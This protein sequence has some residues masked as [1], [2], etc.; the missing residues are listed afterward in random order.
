[1]INSGCSLEKEFS[2]LICM[3]P[4][5]LLYIIANQVNSCHRRAS[6]PLT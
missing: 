6:G 1:M 2:E 5:I 3:N 4:Q